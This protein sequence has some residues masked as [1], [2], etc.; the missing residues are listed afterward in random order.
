MVLVVGGAGYI[1]SHMTQ[2]LRNHEW[3]HLVFDNLE[4]GHEAAVAGSPFVKG[5]L[6][7]E[8]DLN[9][10]FDA[11][12]EIDVVMHFAAYTYVGESVTEPGKYWK[13]NTS[14]VLALLEIMRERG[15]K[16]FIFS[17]T[18]AT[19]GEPRRI[20]LTEDH[21]QNPISPYGQTKLAV[22]MI[23]KDFDH[24]YGLR[25]VA[26]RYF[27][28]AGADPGGAIGEDHR[29]EAHLIPNAI[30]AATG[31]KPPLTVFGNDYDTPDGTCIR[32]YIHVADLAQAHALAIS[33]LRDGGDSRFYNLGNGNG[34]SVAEVIKTVEEVTGLPVPHSIG[35]RRPGDPAR[36][37]GSSAKVKA[38]W[39][40]NPQYPDLRS[41]IEH[42]WA[43]HSSHPNGYEDHS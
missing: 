23:L 9:A 38:D 30:F 15:I 5:D 4:Y 39:N 18:C 41:I 16:K 17:S 27:N 32:D 6:R 33:H 8:A 20:P 14:A 36:L 7:N 40:W 29:P 11:N 24:A 12:P 22:E 19:F 21:P 10:V 42:A 34:Y 25:S 2:W 31:K 3:P 43:W 1:G 35:P 13:N 26:L 28:A 37:I